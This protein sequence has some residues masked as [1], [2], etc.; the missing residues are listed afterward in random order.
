MGKNLPLWRKS[1]ITLGKR[2]APQ[3]FAGTL[4]TVALAAS[5]VYAR[6]DYRGA[7]GRTQPAVPGD[8]C[9]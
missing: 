3:A 9:G 6:D 7:L 2:T 5:S 1:L 8:A 4:V